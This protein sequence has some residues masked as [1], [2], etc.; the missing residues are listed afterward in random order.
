MM[1]ANGNEITNFTFNGIPINS[2]SLSS[3]NDYNKDIPSMSYSM[4]TTNWATI[5]TFSPSADSV[6]NFIA[7]VTYNNNKAPI[8]FTAKLDEEAIWDGYNTTYIFYF[9]VVKVNNTLQLQ[10]KCTN[11]ITGVGFSC[12]LFYK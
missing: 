5:A 9:R 8:V 10:S 12:G 11:A 7:V 2:C 6:N 1:T 4:I 3:S